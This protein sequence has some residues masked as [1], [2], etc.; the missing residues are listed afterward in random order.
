MS[1][2]WRSRHEIRQRGQIADAVSPLRCIRQNP[3]EMEPFDSLSDR[4]A[5]RRENDVRK[6]A[7][8][9]K[10]EKERWNGADVMGDEDSVFPQCDQ[11]HSFIIEAVQ[12]LRF[13]ID[14]RL[15]T[16]QPA[17]DV[18]IEIVVGSKANLHPDGSV[19]STPLD[20]PC[21][22]ASALSSNFFHFCCSPASEASTIAWLSR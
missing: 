12:R 1:Q 18:P 11:K 19:R 17:N 8:F 22:G 3:D 6:R 2:L 5:L 16:K 9:S 10:A 21:G 20:K 4:V 15:Q 14:V 13:K 7:A